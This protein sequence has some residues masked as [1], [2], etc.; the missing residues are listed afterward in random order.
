MKRFITCCLFIFTTLLLPAQT[1]T[2]KYIVQR[3]GGVGG[4]GELTAGAK[5]PEAYDYVYSQNKSSLQL[6]TPGGTT[7]A[8]FTKDEGRLSYDTEET[9]TLFSKYSLIKDFSKNLFEKAYTM[10]NNETRTKEKLSEP[11]WHITHETKVINGFD[12][13]KATTTFTSAGVPLLVNAW[14]S[15]EVAVKDGPFDF[16]GLPGFIFELTAEGHFTATFE[17]FNFDKTKKTAIQGI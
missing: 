3:T 15:S 6:I 4:D 2:G 5:L 10:Q 13:T 9:T 14:Y 8:R 12:C 1:L 7:V 17:N 11:E 16:Y